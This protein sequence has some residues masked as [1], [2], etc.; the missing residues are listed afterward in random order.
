MGP[1]REFFLRNAQQSGARTPGCFL[2]SEAD[3]F[4]YYFVRTGKLYI[5]PL[6]ETRA[7]FK[8]RIGEFQERETTTPIRGEFYT[9]VGRLV[10]IERVLKE[11]PGVWHERIRAPKARP[12]LKWA[13]GKKQLLKQIAPLLPE[14]LAK[15]DIQRYAEPFIGSGAVF[16]FL[17]RKFDIPEVWIGDQNPELVL[18]YRTIQDRVEPLIEQ[19]QLLQEAYGKLD[20]EHQRESFYLTRA[21]FNSSLGIT[22]FTRTSPA[23]IVRTAQLIFLNRT[24]YNGLFRVNA[25]G[26]FNVPFGKYKNPLICD[27][28][29]LQAVAAV[30]G[31]VEIMAGDFERCRDWIDRN[32]FVYFDPPY[33]PISPTSSFNS[34]SKGGFGDDDQVRLAAF[35]QEL[36]Q[37]GARLMLSNSDPKNENPADDFFERLFGVFKIHKLQA[38]RM[39]NSKPEGRGRITELLITNY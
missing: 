33:R 30:L 5:L 12:F 32:T 19:L 9:T 37:K 34:Y 11:V 35:Y 20:L 8:E 39:I 38:T 15:G 26:H 22:D 23:S 21:A 13:G 25:K 28:E 10:P 2:Y 16:F 31:G 27:S 36:D 24:C 4:F 6:D 3:L 29:N 18:A 7:W 14:G 1:D 17:C